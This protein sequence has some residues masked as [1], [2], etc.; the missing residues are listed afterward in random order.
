MCVST[1][2]FKALFIAI[3][4]FTGKIKKNIKVWNLVFDYNFDYTGKS[5]NNKSSAVLSL[6]DNYIHRRVV[7]I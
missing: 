7:I 4:S 1:F 3:K 5:N 6:T 2:T